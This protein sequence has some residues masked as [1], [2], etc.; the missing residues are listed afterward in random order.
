MQLDCQGDHAAICGNGPLRTRRH[1]NIAEVYANILEEVHALV[2]REIFV[3]ELS[4]TG[5]EAWLDVWA[6]GGPEFTDALLD[7]TVAHPIRHNGR[8]LLG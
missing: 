1:N 4:S 8:R 2:R 5:R 3:A 6:Y 7:V